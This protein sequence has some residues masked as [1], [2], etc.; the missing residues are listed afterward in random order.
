MH[1]GGVVDRRSRLEES[2][3][4]GMERECLG[5]GTWRLAAPV[6]GSALD[7]AGPLGVD[8]GHVRAHVTGYLGAGSREGSR[9][10]TP[11]SSRASPMCFSPY[12][13]SKL[14]FSM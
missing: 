7:R 11:R 9:D 8:P 5:G 14:H 1:K 13:F 4:S 10:L 6:P 2:C 3:G 12:V